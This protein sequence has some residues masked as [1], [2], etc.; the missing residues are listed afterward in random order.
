MNEPKY[1]HGCTF[2]YLLNINKAP[3]RCVHIVEKK[4]T[5]VYVKEIFPSKGNFRFGHLADERNGTKCK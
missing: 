5:L 4:N 3:A 2:F 1:Y